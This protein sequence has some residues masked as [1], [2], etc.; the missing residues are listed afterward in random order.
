MFEFHNVM[1]KPVPALLCDFS[2]PV[3][4]DYSYTNEQLLHYSI[5]TK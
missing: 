5:R 3:R 4:L 2:A 1:Y